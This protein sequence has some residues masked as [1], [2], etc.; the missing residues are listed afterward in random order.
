MSKDEKTRYK[1]LS[2]TDRKRFDVEKKIM[3]GHGGIQA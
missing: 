1:V 3:K 2:D